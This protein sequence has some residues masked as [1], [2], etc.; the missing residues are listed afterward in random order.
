VWLSEGETS[1]L[2]RLAFQLKAQEDGVFDSFAGV[3]EL[4]Q[5][6]IREVLV[7]FPA[8]MGI[9][10]KLRDMSGGCSDIKREEVYNG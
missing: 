6:F 3:T 1:E 4:V 9:T 10:W 8:E 7:S 5:T 2:E